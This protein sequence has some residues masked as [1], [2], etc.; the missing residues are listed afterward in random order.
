MRCKKEYADPEKYRKYKRDCQR[1][2]RKK[3]NSGKYPRR[4]WTFKEDMMLFEHSM[5]D[6]ELA[7]VLQ[8]SVESVQMRRH[9][10]KQKGE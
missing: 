3:T 10:L 9:Y 8:R 6:R 5:T 4:R 7:E 1:R 2:Y